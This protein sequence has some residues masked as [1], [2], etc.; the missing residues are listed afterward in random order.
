MKE[1]PIINYMQKDGSF[2][3]FRKAMSDFAPKEEEFKKLRTKIVNI[4]GKETTAEFDNILDYLITFLRHK[5]YMHATS[6]SVTTAQKEIS[7]LT[8]QIKKVQDLLYKGFSDA[9]QHHL[10]HPIMETMSNTGCEDPIYAFYDNSKVVLEIFEKAKKSLKGKHTY[11]TPHDM[12]QILAEELARELDK[13]GE[14]P[15]K[16]RDGNFAKIL[17]ATLKMIP[18]KI[19]EKRISISIPSDLFQVVCKA[20]DD[21]PTKESYSLLEIE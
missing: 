1:K 19:Y 10:N 9:V 21:F 20:I 4:I 13:M 6:T 8:K 15:K 16:Y 7:T 2:I 12:R 14:K 17:R 11:F 18:C 3:S 5:A